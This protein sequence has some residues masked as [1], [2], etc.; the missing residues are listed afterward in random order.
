M[1]EIPGRGNCFSWTLQASN[2]T[3]RNLDF[4]PVAVGNKLFN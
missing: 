2:A 3:L 1:E 4:I